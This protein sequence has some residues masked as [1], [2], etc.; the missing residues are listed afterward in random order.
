MAHDVKVTENKKLI[1]YWCIR[2]IAQNQ[3]NGTK[4]VVKEIELPTEPNL[5]EIASFLHISGADFV[6]VEHNYKFFE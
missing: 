5:D 3:Q 2:A 1:E 6:S 4:T